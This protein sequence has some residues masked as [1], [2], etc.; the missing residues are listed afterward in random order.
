MP[1]YTYI[2][3]AEPIDQFYIGMTAN[4]QDRIQRHNQ[5]RSKA[6]KKGTPHWP[7]V[8]FETFPSKA[9]ACQ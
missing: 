7:V 6:T 3:Y 9:E 4:L 1:F 5:G 2:L 8:Y